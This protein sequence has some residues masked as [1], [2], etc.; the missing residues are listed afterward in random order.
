MY[1]SKY[2]HLS[3]KHMLVFIYLL[4][5]YECRDEARR[6]ML[7]EQKSQ[8][9][10]VKQMKARA[11]AKIDTHLR[12][13]IEEVARKTQQKALRL[14]NQAKHKQISE[15]LPGLMSSDET[16]VSRYARHNNK[17]PRPSDDTSARISEKH[18]S[19]GAQ[20]LQ[21]SRCYVIIYRD[22]TAHKHCLSIACAFC[23]YRSPKQCPE[24]LN[25]ERMQKS[26]T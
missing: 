23:K 10:L 18:A 9:D 14:N 25:S 3:I 6:G 19:S 5:I 20:S 21:V 12:L 4:S 26:N 8:L 7:T 17:R 15:R 2:M 1:T 11:A 13:T 24:L 16:S 22:Y